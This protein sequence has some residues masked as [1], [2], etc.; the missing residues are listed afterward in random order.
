MP[1]NSFWIIILVPTNAP[2]SPLAFCQSAHTRRFD[3]ALQAIEF[4]EDHLGGEGGGPEGKYYP[5]KII[6]G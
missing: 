4:I 3:N 2:P 6:E 5:I 1:A